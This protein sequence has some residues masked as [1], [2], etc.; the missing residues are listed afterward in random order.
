MATI[1]GLEFTLRPR[2]CP[3]KQFEKLI[4]PQRDTTLTKSIEAKRF[5]HYSS[6]PYSSDPDD[7]MSFLWLSIPKGK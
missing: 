2:G 7:E 1:P 5:E 3:K 4:G 6:V